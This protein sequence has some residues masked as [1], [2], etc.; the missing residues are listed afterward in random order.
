MSTILQTIENDAKALAAA[1]FG[2]AKDAAVAFLGKAAGQLEAEVPTLT[3][4]V[5]NTLLEFVPSAVRGLVSGFITGQLTN[6]DD[7]AVAAIKYG[8]SI[9]IA[10][11]NA[12]SI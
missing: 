10:R 4:D 8:L 11:L 1:L 5:V 3:T 12:L 6:L 9:A 7:A 2:S